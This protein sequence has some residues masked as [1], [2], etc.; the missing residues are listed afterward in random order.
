[1]SDVI[2][3]AVAAGIEQLVV[4]WLPFDPGLSCG[5]QLWPPIVWANGKLKIKAE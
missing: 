5:E 4:Q 1:M 3:R 2:A